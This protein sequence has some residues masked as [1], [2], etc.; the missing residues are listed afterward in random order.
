MSLIVT[1]AT[2]EGVV[3]ASESR[4]TYSR[5]EQIGSSTVTREGVHFSDT[6]MKTFLLKNNVGVSSCGDASV[7]GRS[8]A[9]QM[10]LFN[11]HVL[12]AGDSFD[13]TCGKLTEYFVKLNV[14][15]SLNFHAVRY[16]DE[17]GE[18]HPKIAR[19]DI[20]DGGKGQNFE[21]I[22]FNS[23]C[24]ALWD[25]ETLVMTKIIKGGFI[26]DRTKVLPSDKV[27]AEVNTST[28]I[29]TITLKNQFLIPMD[30]RYNPDLQI[31]WKFF[32]LQDGIDF[33]TYAI[34]TT[35]DTMRFQSVPK[36]VGGPIDI[37]VLQSGG[38]KWIAHKELHA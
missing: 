1:V 10:S 15:G 22:S 17:S 35:I 4:T 20:W 8:I 36:T 14:K 27:D 2:R 34:K 3:L 31:E 6:T 29:K 37:L 32:T 25:G 16:E 19:I 7:A 26:V 13:V 5:T 12:A 33:A 38:A 21:P 24:G 18:W 9:A 28:G 30:V 11:E 23:G